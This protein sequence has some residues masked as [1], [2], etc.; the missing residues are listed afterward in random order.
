MTERVLDEAGYYLL[1]GAG[2]E[3]PAT[4]M[5]EARRG[6][7]TRLR[8]GIHLRALERQ[9]GIVPR[10]R[11]LRS[12]QPDAN[13]NGSNQSQHPPSANHR[14]VGDDHA[15]PHGWPFRARGRARTSP[16]CRTR[17]G[18]DRITTAQMEDFA[19]IMRRL[20]RGGHLRPR[21]AGRKIPG[22]APRLGPLDEYLPMSVVAFGPRIR[23]SLAGGASTTSCSTRTSPTTR[24]RARCTRSSDQLGRRPD[25]ATVRVW[26]CLATVGDHLP[27]ELRLMKSVGRLGTYLQGYGDSLVRTNGWDPAALEALPGRR[28]RREACPALDSTPPAPRS[29]S[30]W[31]RCLP[32]ECLS[33]AA[34]GTGPAVRGRDTK[35]SSTLGCDTVI[36][37]GCSP[38]E[39]HPIVDE[40][41]ARA[42]SSVPIPRRP[43]GL[44]PGRAAIST[45]TAV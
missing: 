44:D 31:P 2:G 8:H 26:S 38:A 40:Y 29:S 5:D 36:M 16:R 12:D 1:A 32:P 17:F 28:R 18:I 13:R 19:G 14:F 39:L 25:P 7:E 23:C 24:R 3:G 6:K 22:A 20:F 9:G 15:E 11:R 37:H 42:G 35:H 30:T 27:E 45:P 21:R 34:T 10:R 33:A 43:D 4:L 41:R